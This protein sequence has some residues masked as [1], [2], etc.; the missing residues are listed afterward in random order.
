MH[1]G[2]AYGDSQ[3]VLLVRS[4]AFSRDRPFGFF[5]LSTTSSGAFCEVA[6]D[7]LSGVIGLFTRSLGGPRLGVVGPSN[8]LHGP[9][10]F[11]LNLCRSYEAFR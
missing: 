10:T 11:S 7:V 1:S 3:Q 4:V 8:G 2:N 6:V 9:S 5:V